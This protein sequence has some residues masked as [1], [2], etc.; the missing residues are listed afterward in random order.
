MVKMKSIPYLLVF[1]TIVFTA[2]SSSVDTTQLNAEE[3]FQYAFDLF[4]EED[5]EDALKEFQNIVLQYPGST[6][7]DD[8]QYFL[9]QTYFKREEFLLA[10]YEYSKLIR[11]IPGSPF[12]ADAQYMLAESYYQL[13]PSFQLDQAYTRKAKEEFQ[14]FID[15]FPANPLVDAAEK[16][17]D[18]MNEKLARKEYNNAV[19]YEKMEYN[20]AALDYY[21]SVFEIY[22]DTPY[23]PMALYRKIKLLISTDKK[24]EAVS[25]MRIFLERYPDSGEREEIV[26]LYS[27]IGEGN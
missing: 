9:S 2:C 24:P 19:I 10:A 23:A 21:N 16:K 3:H 20:K 18:E 5:Y 1:F 27:E 6:V 8:A 13:S 14:A 17:I 15:Y 11:D 4:S 22:H 12:V 26:K 7:N 25:N